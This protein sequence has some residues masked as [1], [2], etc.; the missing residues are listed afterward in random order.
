MSISFARLGLSK[1]ATGQR[2]AAFGRQGEEI[3]WK[4]VRPWRVVLTLAGSPLCFLSFAHPWLTHTPAKHTHT[5]Q[6]LFHVC[7]AA[8][9]LGQNHSLKS[10]LPSEWKSSRFQLSW[11]KAMMCRGWNF[12]GDPHIACIT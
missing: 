10:C 4:K 6:D 3:S 2:G 5:H 9:A 12:S 1:G 7:N 8:A 11:L